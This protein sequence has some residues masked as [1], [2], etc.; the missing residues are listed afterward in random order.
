MQNFGH[1]WSNV[2]KQVKE[3][4]GEAESALTPWRVL[5]RTQSS[6]KWHICW[7]WQWALYGCVT[8]VC[9]LA[10]HGIALPP[11][12]VGLTEEQVSELKLC[13]AQAD[14]ALPS[15]GYRHSP[16]PLGR[17]NGRAPN[18]KMSSVLQKAT[19]EASA[20]IAK[21]RSKTVVWLVMTFDCYE[22]CGSVGRTLDRWTMKYAL[23]NIRTKF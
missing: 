16:D 14:T 1:F 4:G 23:R 10:K 13:D 12:M 9:E 5:N 8:D 21:V 22:S 3:G 11:E 19:A 20:I 17:R 7:I 6:I 15:G 2:V 18:D